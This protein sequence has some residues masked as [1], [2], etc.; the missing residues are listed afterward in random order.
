MGACFQS[1]LPGFQLPVI[2][3]LKKNTAGPLTSRFV[4]QTLAAAACL[5]FQRKGFSGSYIFHVKEIKSRLFEAIGNM[6]FGFS[7]RLT[8][9]FDF[10]IKSQHIFLIFWN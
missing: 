10:G 6:N 2:I 7:S 5:L 1:L 3:V 9:K 4:F 8:P